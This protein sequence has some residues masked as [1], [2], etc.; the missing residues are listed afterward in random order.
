MLVLSAGDGGRAVLSLLEALCWVYTNP[1][2][3]GDLC[4][5]SICELYLH[6]KTALKWK[7]PPL[8][9]SF[10]LFGLLCYAL[11]SLSLHGFLHNYVKK[12]LAAHGLL[13][14]VVVR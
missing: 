13:L 11:C 8:A 5:L 4:V 2:L 12:K 3:F 10:Y 9:G 14:S 1:A 7:L 6:L